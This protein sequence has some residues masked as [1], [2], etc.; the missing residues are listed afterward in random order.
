VVRR[1]EH[2]FEGAAETV[3]GLTQVDLP[4]SVLSLSKDPVLEPRDCQ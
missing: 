2:W 1:Q 3:A 4:V